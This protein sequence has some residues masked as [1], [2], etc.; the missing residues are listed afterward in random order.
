MLK[1]EVNDRVTIDEILDSLDCP[2]YFVQQ[3]I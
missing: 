3:I 2:D 1:I